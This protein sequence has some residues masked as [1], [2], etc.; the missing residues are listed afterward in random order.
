MSQTPVTTRPGPDQARLQAVMRRVAEVASPQAPVLTVYLDLRPEAQGETP[1]RREGLTVLR[2]RLRQV[3]DSYA[4]HTPARESLDADVERLESYLAEQ[5][6]ALRQAQGLAL[7]ACREAG[8]WETILSDAP[9]ETQAGAG[10][11][12]DLFQL[13]DLLDE[14]VTSVVAVVDTNTCRLFVTRR[15]SLLERPGPDE[16]SEEHKRTD[17]GGWSQSRYQ[18][19]IDMQDRRFAAEAAQAINDLVVRERARHLV[20]AGDE[21][22]VSVLEPELSEPSRAVL[23]HVE[24]ISLHAGEDQVQAEVE[25]VLAALRA[26]DEQDAADRAIAGWRAGDLGLVGIDRVNEALERGQVYEL[27]IDEEADVDETLRAELVRQASL[28]GAEVVTV[29]GHPQLQAAGGVA[30]T[31]RFRV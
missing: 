26:A 17:Q 13:A 12:A 27:V 29:K 15:G 9:F 2:D 30:A 8:L 31:L 19:H 22:A 3:Q 1:G 20:L 4:P 16:G 21:R 10:P 18:R 11:T 25:P 14:A 28:T 5:A 7:F 6:D 23:D 24:R